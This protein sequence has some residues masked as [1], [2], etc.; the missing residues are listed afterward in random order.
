M[1]Q[2]HAYLKVIGSL[3]AESVK[4][5]KYEPLDMGYE[6]HG[7]WEWFAAHRD[8]LNRFVALT[9]TEEPS[10]RRQWA[11]SVEV[12]AGADTDDRYARELVNQFVTVTSDSESI[13]RLHEAL[14]RGVQRA[15]ALTQYDLRESYVSGVRRLSDTG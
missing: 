13:Q 6:K 4:A 7:S 15:N 2:Q 12:W 11:Y 1:A 3:F 14:E 8:D 10:P 9:L 5:L